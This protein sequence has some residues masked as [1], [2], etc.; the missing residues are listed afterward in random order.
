MKSKAVFFLAAIN[1]C[2][3]CVG[4]VNARSD[5]FFS[6]QDLDSG[7]VNSDLEVSLEVGDEVSV[8][9][10]FSTHGPSM[11]EIDM[12][13]FFEVNTSVP[14]VVEFLGGETFQFDITLENPDIILDQRWQVFGPGEVFDEGQTLEISV[15]NVTE[16]TGMVNS[17]TGPTFF[18]QGYDPDTDAFLFGRADFRVIGEGSVDLI[19]GV[20]AGGLANNGMA[21]D[22]VFGAATV[23]VKDDFIP[24]DLNG[25]GVVTLLDIGLFVD[26]LV[27]G[28]YDKAADFNCDDAVDLLDVQPFIDAIDFP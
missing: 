10:Y 15:F 22:P 12:G 24:G 21:V 25:D 28:G 8:F 4:A 6:T 11:T 3:F 9:V 16:G 13:G 5:V 20:R 2:L 18:D 7:A 19:T 26:L 14:G 27:E 23:T 17:N 1:L